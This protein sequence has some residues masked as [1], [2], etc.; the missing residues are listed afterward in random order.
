[1]PAL[2]STPQRRRPADLSKADCEAALAEHGGNKTHAAKALGVA[3]NT[4]KARLRE[5]Q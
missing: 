5:L 4:F 2:P 3:L 1:M